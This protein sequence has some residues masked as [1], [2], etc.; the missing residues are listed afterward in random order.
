MSGWRR[1]GRAGCVA[2]VAVLATAGTTAAADDEPPGAPPSVTARVHAGTTDGPA[3]VR[4]SIAPG[5][6]T[7]FAGNGDSFAMAA[8]CPPPSPTPPPA[9]APRPTPPP[10]PLKPALKPTPH[11]PAPKPPAPPEPAPPAPRPVLHRAPQPPPRPTPP[12]PPAPAPAAVPLPKAPIAPRA[13]H[14]S[15]TKP[16]EGGTSLVT[17]TLVLTA[18]AVLAAALLRPRSGGGRS[19]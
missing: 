18:P 5:C 16:A 10:P 1:A 2:F 17:L 11:K 4:V 3:T 13:Y 7:A 12:P 9:P 8:L 15:V 6:L 19:R 14:Q